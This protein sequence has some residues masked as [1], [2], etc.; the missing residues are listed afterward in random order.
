METEGRREG[1][2]RDKKGEK[3]R[4]ERELDIQGPQPQG[5]IYRLCVP[6]LLE[7]FQQK[8]DLFQDKSLQT[9]LSYGSKTIKLKRPALGTIEEVLREWE[10]TQPLSPPTKNWTA[11]TSGLCHGWALCCWFPKHPQLQ[12]GGLLRVRPSPLGEPRPDSFPLHV[13]QLPSFGALRAH[14]ECVSGELS[15]AWGWAQIL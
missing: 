10:G 15:L 9:Y 6:A 13:P 7:W 5:S 11:W 1:R 8:L 12:V 4:A 3:S 2:S 14:P